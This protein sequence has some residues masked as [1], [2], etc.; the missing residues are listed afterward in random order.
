MD[1]QA[2]LCMQARILAF[3][4]QAQGSHQWMGY[5][6]E[7]TKSLWAPSSGVKPV[8]PLDSGALLRCNLPYFLNWELWG[9]SL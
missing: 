1:T 7:P 2:C 6:L 4:G 3:T 5:S 9:P 8:E